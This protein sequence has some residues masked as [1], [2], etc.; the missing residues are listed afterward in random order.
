MKLIIAEKPSLAKNIANALGASKR[1]D[2]YIENDKY[3]ISWAFGHLFT[4]KNIDDY[5]G[6][7]CKWNEVELP[8]IPEP[9]EFKIK[10]KK[11]LKTKQEKIDA[12]VKH[13][14]EILRKLSA[15]QDVTEIVN[16]GD[17]DREGQIIIDI[18]V[19]QIKCSKPV[20]RL[21]LPE[22]TESTIK[23]QIENLDSNGKYYTLA[24]EGYARTYMDWLFGINLTRYVSVKVNKLLPIGRVLIPVVK[25]IFDREMEIRNFV[26][27][28]YFQLE[29]K[30]EK[31]GVEI[32]LTLKT[33]KFEENE[34]DAAEN[35]ANHLNS[36]KGI[37]KE[38]EKK[39]IKKQPS[40]LFSLSKL[41]TQLS[42]K[43]KID[44]TTS[45]D[46][47]QNLYEKGYITYP[48]TNTEYLAEN[49]KDKVKEIIK[50]FS[51]YNLA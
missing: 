5:L 49:E 10:T 39:A 36:F 1:G 28:K 23:N 33:K 38:I 37:V 2:G 47:I 30:T 45:L 11:D 3:I 17:A 14:V 6:R 4:L 18:I 32:P 7:K 41:Q 48:R 40:K 44:F 9:F 50:T 8:F 46:V 15:R 21:W 20:M 29:S 13:Q 25:F 24:Q 12:G 43:N 35:L 26:K 22:Q 16:A 31:D 19:Q 51:E 42:K 34:K 27:K